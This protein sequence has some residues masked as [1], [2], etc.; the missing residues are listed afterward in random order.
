MACDSPVGWV[1]AAALSPPLPCGRLSLETRGHGFSSQFLLAAHMWHLV[2]RR[3]NGQQWTAALVHGWH[4]VEG[5]WD[6]HGVGPPA[7]PTVAGRPHAKANVG[8]CRWH[9]LQIRAHSKELSPRHSVPKLTPGVGTEESPAKQRA[10][11]PAL[12]LAHPPPRGSL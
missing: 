3:P 12:R 7:T 6:Q 8:L 10:Q 1:P 2:T 9:C 11:A 5:W 4:P